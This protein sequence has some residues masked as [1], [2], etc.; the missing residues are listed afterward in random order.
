MN[1][2]R[3]LCKLTF[4]GLIVSNLEAAIVNPWCIEKFRYHKQ[5]IVKVSMKKHIVAHVSVYASTPAQLMKLKK[6]QQAVGGSANT[7]TINAGYFHRNGKPAGGLKVN[8]SWHQQPNTR[9]PRG[10]IGLVK[11]RGQQTVI[12]DRLQSKNHRIV[13]DY[14]QYSWWAQA[15]SLVE[16]GPLLI[17]NG[18]K[19]SWQTERL[20]PSFVK[21]PYA[22]SAVCLQSNGDLSFWLVKGGDGFFRKLGLFKRKGL[23]LN[24]LTD[25]LLAQGCVEALN[26]DGGYSS[27]IRFGKKTMVGL[28]LNLLPSRS[29]TSTLNLTA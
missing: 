14:H 23:N 3:S 19:L 15:E 24:T 26:L 22:R 10:V 13:S 7:V 9:A 28:P 20:N 1:I 18:Q 16:A 27:G 29:I 4:Y 25:F 8:G 12:F 5:T 2:T 6:H 17:K 11:R 21:H